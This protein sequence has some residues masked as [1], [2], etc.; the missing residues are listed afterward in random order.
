MRDVKPATSLTA[1]GQLLAAEPPLADPAEP[2][3]REF[4]LV[5]LETFAQ[6]AEAEEKKPLTNAEVEAEAATE[7]KPKKAGGMLKRK[8]E[9]KK[10][11]AAAAAAAASAGNGEGWRVQI[12]WGR[13]LVLLASE[14][15]EEDGDD[16]DDQSEGGDDTARKEMASPKKRARDDDDESSLSPNELLGQAAEHY[17]LGLEAMPSG[18]R[19]SSSSED[20]SQ[21]DPVTSFLPPTNSVTARLQTLLSVA[22]SV[23]PLVER[24]A[25]DDADNDDRLTW[26]TWAEQIYGQVIDEANASSSG[27]NPVAAAQWAFDA[28]VGQG[29][30]WLGLGS[31]LADALETGED[32]EQELDLSSEEVALAKGVLGKALGFLGTARTLKPRYTA[33][34]KADR[35]AAKAEQV[36]DE[37]DEVAPLLIECCLTLSA[38]MGDEEAEERDGLLEGA[39]EEGW[40]EEDEEEEDGDD[41]DE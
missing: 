41:D 32:D 31:R 20:V 6:A 29:S 26:A 36:D 39:R 35:G 7:S 21:R 5:A 22:N 11:K 19:S 27:L 24:L 12:A 40:V 9:K 14:A 1:L 37:E 8:K 33:Q 3:P 13:C 16:D 38:L 34:E 18:K 4:F 25:D 2:A 28:A 17:A 23:A 15:L 10:E 30:V